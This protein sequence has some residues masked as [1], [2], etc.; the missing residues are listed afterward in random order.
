[1]SGD[2][3][4]EPLRLNLRDCQAQR[5]NIHISEILVFNPR[6]IIKLKSFHPK[7]T[8]IFSHLESVICPA[9]KFH[10]TGLLIKRKILNIHLGMFFDELIE[11]LNGY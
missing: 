6:Q 11:L 9:S 4:E 8:D 2:G 10:D 7:Y 1:M 5:L 3:A